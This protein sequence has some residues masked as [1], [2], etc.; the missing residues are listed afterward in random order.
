MKPINVNKYYIKNKPKVKA[1]K[2]L[3]ILPHRVDL[4][5]MAF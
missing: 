1:Y 3:I 4:R 2:K 5:L